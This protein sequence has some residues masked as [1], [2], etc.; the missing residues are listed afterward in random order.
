[1]VSAIL[2]AGGTGSRMQMAK[3]K[4]LIELFGKPLLQHSL[5]LF[6]SMQEIKEIIVV[7]AAPYRAPFSH[8]DCK[9]AIPGARR[10]DSVANGFAQIADN[11]ECV[12]VHD[13]A[14]PLICKEQ[15]LQLIDEGKKSG[16]ATLAV[17]VKAT[18]K[19]TDPE[20]LVTQTLDRSCLWEIQTPQFLK[21]EL[22][23]QGLAHAEKKELTVTD[24]VSLAENLGHPVKLVMGA[25]N[26]L[27]IT[28]KEDLPLAEALSNHG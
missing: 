28:T 14:R 9:F 1:M 15:V 20:Q 2:L 22:L 24:D 27:K 23:Q 5:E 12:I 13:A 18:I 4:Q 10:Q 6:I 19:Q 21:K 25:Y 7:L 16:A 8:F 3:P 26:N 11:A 17:P